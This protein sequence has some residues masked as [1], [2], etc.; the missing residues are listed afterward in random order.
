VFFLVLQGHTLS[1][2]GQEVA[3]D[4]RTVT[5]ASAAILNAWNVFHVVVVNLWGVF[6]EGEERF[7]LIDVLHLL[8]LLLIAV[9]LLF[10]VLNSLCHTLGYLEIMLHLL[11]GCS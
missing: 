3:Q 5:S 6:L 11:H 1:I 2:G 4:V 7:D 8:E 10:E 9:N